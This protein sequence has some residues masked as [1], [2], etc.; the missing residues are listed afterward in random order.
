[1]YLAA[2]ELVP[3]MQEEKNIR[4]SVAQFVL[5]ILGLVLVWLLIVLLP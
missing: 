2:S 1:M 5:F 3:E 4:K